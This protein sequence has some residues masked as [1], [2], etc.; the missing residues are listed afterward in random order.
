[1]ANPDLDQKVHPAFSS[2]FSEL[3]DPRRIAKGNHLYPLEEILFLAIAA[4]VSGADSWTAIS[5]FGRAKLDWLSRF[6]PFENGIPSHDVLGKVFAALDSQAFSR[7][8]VSWIESM[9]RITSGEVVSIDGKTLRGSEDKANGKSALHVV[10]AFATANGLCLGQ[11]KVDSKS[12]EITAIPELL[13]L[14]ALKGCIVTLDAMGCQKNIAGAIKKKE[15]DY[16]LM[17]KGNQKELKDQIE[18]L[19]SITAVKAEYSSNELGHGRIEHRLCEVV[20]QLE[21][22][23]G[24]EEWPGL[25]SV[26]RITSERIIKQTGK[27]TA[28]TRYYITSLKAEV[29]LIHDAV[30]SH[31]AVENNLHWSLDVIFKED[32]SLKKK[33]HSALNFNKIA[34]MALTLIDQEKTTKKSKP[35]KRLLAALDD[36]YRAKI[37]KV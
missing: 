4:V 29:K 8:F 24:R 6:Y 19:F 7:C 32:A 34:K 17:V 1:M 37:L 28:E 27:G 20:D 12:N 11:V 10:S 13:E 21:F 25:K 31:W 9:A 35:S 23:D 26:V 2:F 22:L 36:R 30:R 3:K 15:A 33:D 16:M 5:L 14:L 18:K